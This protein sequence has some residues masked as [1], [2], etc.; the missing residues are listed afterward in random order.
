MNVALTL[1]AIF[2]LAP[3]GDAPPEGVPLDKIIQS[4]VRDLG[5]GRY[6]V[7]ERATLALRRIGRPA[8]AA[9]ERAAQSDD[10]EVRVRARQMLADV[11]LGI[12][13]DW[14]SE[15]VLLVRHYDRLGDNERYSALRRLSAAVGAKAVPFLV[16]RMGAGNEREARYALQ[17]LQRMNNDEVWQQVIRLITK[18]END[19]QAQALAWARAQSGQALQA[20][21]VLTKNQIKD[22]TRNKV[23]EAGVQDILKKLKDRK[24][25]DAAR[26]ADK[27]AKAAPKDARFLYL[28]AEALVAL[29]KDKDALALRKRALALNPDAEAPHYLAGEVLGKLGRRR[30]AARE[31]ERILEIQPNDGVYDINAYL[32]LSSIYAASGIFEQAAQYLEKAL[33][34]YLK[35]REDGKGGMGIIGGTVESL[36]MEINRLRRKAARFPTEPDAAIEDEI[37][38]NEIKV[39]INVTVKDGKLEDLQR[40]LASV[41]AQLSVAVQ[42]PDLKLFDVAAATL[43]YDKDK[44]QIAVMLH[45]NPACKPM[46][47]EA[48]ARETRVAIHCGDCTYIFKIDAATGKAT[49]TADSSRFEKDYTI[50]L[51]PGVKISAYTD[52]AVHINGKAHEWERLLKGVPFDRLPR[53]LDIVLEGTTPAGK[54]STFRLKVKVTE[55][56]IKPLAPKPKP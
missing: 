48:K 33:A 37:A 17:A 2:L 12:S 7:R 13:P 6:D 40:A 22:A 54:R 16:L 27:F 10:P 46:P 45:D 25:R 1:S 28:R 26:A 53:Q 35:A 14:P 32:R 4:L 51:R 44:K 19:R 38:E 3:P 34:R 18:P 43:R 56:K 39:N 47:F 30:L 42:P 21:E 41:A 24:H 9:L 5:A 15:I 36:Q 23:I 8:L 49:R 31:W 50:T 52:V 55:P 20:L 11:R 29:D